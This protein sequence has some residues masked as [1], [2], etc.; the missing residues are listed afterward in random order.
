MT[1]KKLKDI[2]KG[3]EE[4]R[5]LIDFTTDILTVGETTKD[6]FVCFIGRKLTRLLSSLGDIEIENERTD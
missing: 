5:E 2:L 3:R 6:A 1:G 4:W